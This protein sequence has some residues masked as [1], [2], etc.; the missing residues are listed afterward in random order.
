[1]FPILLGR[2]CSG[3]VV[4]VGDNVTK[5]VSGDEVYALSGFSGGTYAQF[6]VVSAE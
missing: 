3:E 4:A 2:D 5:F 6:A 1:M